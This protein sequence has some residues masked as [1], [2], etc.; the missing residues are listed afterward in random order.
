MLTLGDVERA[1][2]IRD[3]ELGALV[4]RYLAQDDPEP[5]RSELSPTP[6]DDD[7]GDGAGDGQDAAA[8]VPAGAVTLD[9]LHAQVSIGGL[10][11]PAP[12]ERQLARRDA[13]AP[14]RAAPLA[15]P[16]PR[17]GGT[18]VDPLPR[19]APAGRRRSRRGG[20]GWASC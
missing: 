13:V 14:A 5:G 9:R 10:A 18:L 17:P 1:I 7:A 6:G 16:R 8:D 4:V 11:H 2:A 19:R 3:P 12:T 20:W 15:P